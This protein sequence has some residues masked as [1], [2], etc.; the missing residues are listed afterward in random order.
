[1]GPAGAVGS[2][3]AAA[4][5]SV[6][7]NCFS[8]KDWATSASA[9]SKRGNDGKDPHH[10]TPNAA[11]PLSKTASR[12]SGFSCGR[13]KWGLRFLSWVRQSEVSYDVVAHTES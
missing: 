2:A 8:T 6:I 3:G 5:F 9:C 7:P 12:E 13:E 4:G 1:M 11:A 10:T